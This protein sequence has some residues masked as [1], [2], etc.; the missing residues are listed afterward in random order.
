MRNQRSSGHL[1]LRAA[2]GAL[3]FFQ[4]YQ[5]LVRHF[6]SWAPHSFGS[7]RQQYHQSWLDFLLESIEKTVRC[8]PQAKYSEIAAGL[9]EAHKGKLSSVGNSRWRTIQYSLINT[10]QSAITNWSW[11]YCSSIRQT[12]SQRTFRRRTGT[13]T[14]RRNVASDHNKGAWWRSEGQT[15]LRAEHQILPG[16]AVQFSSFPQHVSQRVLATKLQQLFQTVLWIN[17]LGIRSD[18]QHLARCCRWQY[19]SFAAEKHKAC[20]SNQTLVKRYINALAWFPLRLS[21][22]LGKR[23]AEKQRQSWVSD[24]DKGHL[25]AN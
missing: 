6:V 14:R 5:W 22:L 21:V 8:Q 2:R 25:N 7:W 11:S 18:K 15:E 9:L 12:W 1:G 23:K 16:R 3:H 20:Y 24:E 4:R 13:R 19:E 10:A 17:R